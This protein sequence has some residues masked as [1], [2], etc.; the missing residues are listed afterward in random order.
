M[1]AVTMNDENRGVLPE[2]KGVA[3]PAPLDPPLQALLP[4]TR[5]RTQTSFRRS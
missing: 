5:E 2:S 1:F 3:S 4:M